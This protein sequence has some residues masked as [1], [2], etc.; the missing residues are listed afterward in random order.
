MKHVVSLSGGVSSAVCADRV[1]NRYG[2]ENVI[3]WFADTSWEDPDLH[4][5]MADCMVRWGG[6]MITYKDGRNPLQVAE[7]EHIIPNDRVATCTRVLKIIP[8]VRFLET[9]EKPVTIYLGL[10]W[11]EQDRMA[12]PIRNYSEIPGVSVDFPLM[13]DPIIE[14]NYFDLVE[15]DWGIRTSNA[16]R[17]G[18]THDNC[19]GRCVKAGMKHWLLLR[20]RNPQRFAE[21]RD[22]EA[23]QRAIGDARANYALLRKTEKGVKRPLPLSELEQMNLEIDEEPVRGDS[24]AC[25]CSIG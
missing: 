12:A 18:F 14:E 9:L 23:R 8:F 16:Y 10:D 13:W 17:D 21:V 20:K 3:L 1:I 5:F 7:D 11:R 22:W 24:T 15:R 6:E 2:R 25:F 4:R 19:G